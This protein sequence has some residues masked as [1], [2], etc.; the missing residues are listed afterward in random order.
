[1]QQLNNKS[2]GDSLTAIEWNQ[3]PSELQNIIT[4]EAIAL[5]GGD[6]NQLGKAI[7]NKVSH[8]DFYTDS[9]TA[10]AYVLSSLTA[11]QNPTRYENGMR[12]RF[13]AANNSTGASTVNVVGLGI[14]TIVL[15]STTNAIRADDINISDLVTLRYD[16]TNF[17]LE[18]STQTNLVTLSGVVANSK[19]LGI[20]NNPIIRDNS[21]ILEAFEQLTS[22]T[23]SPKWGEIY[24]N[25][26]QSTGTFSSAE[27]TSLPNNQVVVADATGGGI[28]RVYEDSGSTFNAQGTGFVLDSVE[29]M[30]TLNATDFAVV[31]NLGGGDFN[32]R[33]FNW[34][35]ASV[36]AVG[37]S[38]TIPDGLNDVSIAALDENTV[39]AI[40]DNPH[41]LT[42][43]RFSGSSW[44]QLGNAFTL[45]STAS[46]ISITAIS[47]NQVAI[48][49]DNAT[50]EGLGMFTFDGVDFSQV[51]VTTSISVQND[52]NIMAISNDTLIYAHGVQSPLVYT[53][54]NSQWTLVSDYVNRHNF[55]FSFSRTRMCLIRPNRFVMYSSSDN[56]NVMGIYNTTTIAPHN[57][58]DL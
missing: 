9:G 44:S 13:M 50:R 27:I 22:V 51:G 40:T 48:V 35:G 5:S 39:V 4:S 43:F 16:G 28:I 11:N 3:V 38:F 19:N 6:L 49:S 57:L 15:A 58:A 24:F 12:I 14:K 8:G 45:G 42:A 1:M 31:N 37:S 54:I 29:G 23:A 10:N 20:I 21:N 41:S 52:P 2:T 56:L 34:N 32:L 7:I 55:N 47:N 25:N 17:V 26:V 18:S 46:D 53:F 36:T 33:R 30:A